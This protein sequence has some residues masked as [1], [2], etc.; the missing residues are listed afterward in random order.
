MDHGKTIYMFRFS[1]PTVPWI[2]ATFSPIT[3]LL[4]CRLPDTYNKTSISFY[5]AQ[6]GI[7]FRILH[8]TLTIPRAKPQPMIHYLPVQKWDHVFTR[9]DYDSYVNH[10]TYLLGQPQMQAMVRRGGIAWHLAIGC[11]G[12]GD[13]GK[14][15]T[16]WG[17]QFNLPEGFMEATTVEL[18]LLCGAYECVTGAP[19][20]TNPGGH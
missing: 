3:A 2:L 18:D 5:L 13:V 7:Q 8:P 4:I 19:V 6:R 17:H 10:R 14:E 9:Q 20:T 12:L 1:E 11:L 16:F 15:P